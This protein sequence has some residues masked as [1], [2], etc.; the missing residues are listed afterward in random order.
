MKDHFTQAIQKSIDDSGLK[1][2]DIAKGSGIDP[3]T[4][5]RFIHGKRSLKLPAVA[6]LCEFL[7]LELRQVR[8]PK[9]KAK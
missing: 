9:R 7:G 4:L 8:K 5:S 3:G 6:R 1:A 2:F